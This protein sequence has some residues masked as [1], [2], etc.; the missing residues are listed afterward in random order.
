MDAP[1]RLEQDNGSAVARVQVGPGQSLRF[2]E[3]SDD[4]RPYD[5]YHIAVYVTDFGGS[6]AKLHERGLVSQES[7]PYQYLFQE[8]VDP[9][10]GNL[11][12]EIEHDAR[13]FTDP[14]YARPSDIRNPAQR[15]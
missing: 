11:L 12:Y 9:E 3:T 14:M 5:G 6:H 1:A 2:R 4:I 7:N 15:Q 10:Y 13:T 8:I